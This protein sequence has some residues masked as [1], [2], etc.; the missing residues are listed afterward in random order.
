[1]VVNNSANIKK[2]CHIKSLNIKKTMTYEVGNPDP[3]YTLKKK[4]F[5]L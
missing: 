2:T 4:I 5:F 3:V 1:M